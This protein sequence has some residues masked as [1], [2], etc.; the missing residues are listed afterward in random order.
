VAIIQELNNPDPQWWDRI[1]A[2]SAPTLLLAGGPLSHVPQHLFAEALAL[3]QNGRSAEIP[4][5]H[6]IH[7]D[8]PDQFLALVIPFLAS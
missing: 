7:R 6:H 8:A 5:G 3:L 4:V 2:V 1:D